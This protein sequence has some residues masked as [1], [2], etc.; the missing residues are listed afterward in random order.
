VLFVYGKNTTYGDIAGATSTLTA[1]VVLVIN[2]DITLR[3][4]KFIFDTGT[5]RTAGGS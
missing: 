2:R 3:R 1:G 4:L 5:S